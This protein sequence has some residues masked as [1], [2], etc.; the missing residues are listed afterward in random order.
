[1]RSSANTGGERDKLSH[2]SQTNMTFNADTG[3]VY[4][5]RCWSSMVPCVVRED[6]VTDTMNGKL[7]TFAHELDRWTAVEAF[8]SQIPGASDPGHGPVQRPARVEIPATTTGISPTPSR[9]SASSAPMAG[10]A[11]PAAASALRGERRCRTLDDVR[12]H[13][14]K[15]PLITLREMSPEQRETH[16]GPYRAGFTINPCN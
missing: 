7:H 12:G 8:A 10:R 3:Y 9:T 1:M 5:H 14:I 11:D 2:R 4:P 6:I 16:R 13:T 15:S